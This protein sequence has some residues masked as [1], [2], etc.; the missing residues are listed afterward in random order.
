MPSLS[1]TVPC[2]VTCLPG[3]FCRG[4][5]NRIGRASL[6]MNNALVER[7]DSGSGSDFALS[8]LAARPTPGRWAINTS[9]MAP[10]VCDPDIRRQT[11]Y[12]D[13]DTPTIHPIVSAQA[14]GHMRVLD[15]RSRYAPTHAALLSTIPGSKHAPT[16]ESTYSP[17]DWPLPSWLG[18]VICAS[19][20][21]G[22]VLLLGGAR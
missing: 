11:R 18:K 4:R 14:S 13:P 20:Y 6:A 9:Q 1:A 10:R 7:H 15:A 2:G 3:G 22:R 8:G 16:L 12:R 5:D 21:I 19:S 17:L